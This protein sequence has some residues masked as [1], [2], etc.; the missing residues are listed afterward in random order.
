MAQCSIFTENFSETSTVLYKSSG[1][2]LGLQKLLRQL[3]KFLDKLEWGMGRLTSDHI[4][5]PDFD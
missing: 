1:A 5:L 2:L 4:P 3:F